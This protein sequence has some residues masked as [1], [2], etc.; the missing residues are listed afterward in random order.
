M[1]IG[2]A[3]GN[4][5]RDVRDYLENLQAKSFKDYI[6]CLEDKCSEKKCHNLIV[7]DAIQYV[8]RSL[9][10][11][12]QEESQSTNNTSECSLV[13]RKEPELLVQYY[14][15]NYPVFESETM[16]GSNSP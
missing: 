6:Q 4:N 14:S 3:F 13:R 8:L 9:D 11:L 10:K 12:N 2:Q 5:V 16:T 7:I 1:I 15:K